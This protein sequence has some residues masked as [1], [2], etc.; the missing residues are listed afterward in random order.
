MEYDFSGYATKNDLVCSDGRTILHG[1]FKDMDGEQVPLVWQHAHGE[2]ANILGHAILENRADGVYAYATFNDTENGK[3]AKQLVAHGDLKSLSIW[4]NQLK[5]R[6]YDVLHG[7][8]REVSLVISGANPGAWI[9]NISIAHSDGNVDMLEDEAIICTGLKPDVIAH[10]DAAPTTDNPDETVGDVFD[11]LS[12]KQKT[13]VYAMI[14]QALESAVP[15]APEAPA[16]PVTHADTT[17]DDVIDHSDKEGPLYMSRNV[18]D[19]TDSDT[20][21]S[22]R[23]HLT[24]AQIKTIVD[25]AQLP[26]S[27]FKQA[28]FAHA[29]EYGIDNIDLLFPDAK[30][31][32]DMPELIARQADWV[33]KVLDA[34][35]HAPFGKIKSLVADIT[36]AEARAKGYVKGAEKVEEVLSMLR[37][38]TSPTT[39]YK[40]QKLDRDDIIDITDFDVIAWLKWEIRFMLNEEIARAILIGD[41]R[42][43]VSPDKIK[44]PA[45]QTDGVGIRS[46]ANDSALFAVPVQLVSNISPEGMIDAITRARVS[47]R[48]SGTPSLYTTD[49]LIIDMLMIKDKMGRRLYDTEAALAAALRVKEIVPVEV[50]E[51]NPEIVAI[52]VNLVDYTVGTNKGGEVNFF[53]DFDIDFNQEKYLMETRPSGALTKPKSAIVIRRELGTLA[54]VAAPS[55]NGATNVITIPTATGVDYLINDVIVASGA[56]PA[57]TEDTTIVAA[58]KANYYFSSN[59]TTSWTFVYTP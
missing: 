48:G 57:I 20:K 27:T 6:G 50:M 39:I 38:T 47:Y 52:V 45:G 41:G 26:G 46:I 18:F 36:A 53:S 16:A 24:H 43:V 14:G 30:T 13:V 31:V 17:D 9:D 34:V 15:A 37:R 7:V 10:A 44:D 54:T 1:A 5:Q 32:G 12:E 19:N 22:T 33:P 40:K 2:P 49:S 56:Q 55:F 35:K 25:E 58:P 28:F 23:K 51:E 42:S 4:A 3:L 11:T 59:I 8:I 29:G 21:T